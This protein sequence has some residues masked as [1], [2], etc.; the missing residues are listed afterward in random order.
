MRDLIRTYV[1]GFWHYDLW[2]HVPELHIG[3][4]VQHAHP[5][6]RNRWDARLLAH[7]TWAGIGRGLPSETRRTPFP[8][9]LTEGDET[10]NMI[11][12]GP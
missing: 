12:G 10:I 4:E 1:R 6:A 8:S 7:Y 2:Q 9:T 5:G 11:R 3:V